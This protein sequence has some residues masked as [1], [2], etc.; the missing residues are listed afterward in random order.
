VVRSDGASPPHAYRAPMRARMLPDLPAGTGAERGLA[1]GLVGIGEALAEVPADVEEAVVATRAQHGD[2]AAR[3]VERFACL[4]D[5]TFV[6][7]RDRDGMFHL[8]RLAGP[9][10]YDDTRAARRVGLHHVRPAR[11]AARPFGEDDVP[12]GVSDTFRRGGLNLQRIRAA[13]ADAASLR[14]WTHE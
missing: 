9:W 4:P 13:G 1:S 2:K 6:W 5:G 7:T 12:A 3:M 11:W 14:L 10:R 8:G